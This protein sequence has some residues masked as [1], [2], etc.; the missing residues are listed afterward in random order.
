MPSASGLTIGTDE[1]SLVI[2]WDKNNGGQ[3]R[4]LWAI[5]PGLPSLLLF[6]P[7]QLVTVVCLV[8]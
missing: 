5:R 4:A 3:S 6:L 1:Q 8:C 7:R 2:F